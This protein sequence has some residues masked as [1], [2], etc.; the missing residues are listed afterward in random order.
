[1][2]ASLLRPLSLL[3]TLTCLLLVLAASTAL[4]A[5][6]EGFQSLFNGTSLEG[7]DG[8]PALWR[9]E[10]GTITGETSAENPIPHNSFL[11]W[12]Q[13]EVDD[14]DL[15]FEY[16]FATDKGNSGIQY[17]SWEDPEK[18][19]KWV[20]AG[21][22]ADFDAG[23]NYAGIVYG[24][25][26]RGILANRG[27]ETV[28][29]EDHKPKV[30]KQFAQS[31][32]LKPHVKTD[33]WNS[34]RVLAQGFVITHEVN[35]Q[36]M[37]KC[38]D[39][40]QQQRRRSGLLGIQVH[41][42]P[43][44]KIQI[45]NIRLKRLKLGDQKKVAFIAGKP[46]HSYAGHEHNAGCLLL[47]KLLNENVPQVLATVY[48][49]GWPQDPTALDNADAIVIFCDGGARHP[50]LPYLEPLDKL[51]KK[52]VGLALLHYAVEV[53]RGKEG[54]AFLDWTGGY[55]ETDWSVNP[56]FTAEFTTFAQHPV[57]RGVKPFSVD[58]EWYYHMRFR[59]NM[60]GVTPVLTCIPPDKTRQ[61]PDGAHSNNPTVRAGKGQPEHVGWARQRPD[62]GRGF[63]FTGG[64][65]HWNWANDSFRTLVLNGIVWAAGLDVPAGGV[66]TPTPTLDELLVNQDKPQPANFDRAKVEALLESWKQ[67]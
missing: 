18:F 6:E 36:L 59:E 64:H 37:S 21:Y 33:G 5:D 3:S 34:Y 39:E 7:W 29:G 65:W 55:F 66:A 1:M 40:D 46:S 16:R 57:T 60:E 54:Q 4:A 27:Q 13:G 31:A 45:R 53:P 67:K 52:G 8:D 30:V 10:D 19:G 41:K 20:M 22:Q 32:D 42:G 2:P 63:G 12:R 61:R 43:P 28:I 38:T 56:H 58:D 35:G 48:R 17:R 25:K 14:F 49:N 24:E 11:I 9:V 26:Y 23:N 62:G 44:M 51:M 15:R 47:A 50:V